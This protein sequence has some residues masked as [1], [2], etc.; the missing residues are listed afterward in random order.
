MANLMIT[1][2]TKKVLGIVVSQIYI[3]R[4]LYCSRVCKSAK[5]LH[6]IRVSNRSTFPKPLVILYKNKQEIFLHC[7][8]RTWWKLSPLQ[9][10]WNLDWIS[11]GGTLNM[12]TNEIS[13]NKYQVR[14]AIK[15]ARTNIL[16][17]VSKRISNT[18]IL[19]TIFH[20]ETINNI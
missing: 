17:I 13:M 10:C 15:I 4:H 2:L 19:L 5:Q 9:L 11:Y 3:D 8:W 16:K 1:L 20:N 6:H 18:T 7:K 14:T 12:V